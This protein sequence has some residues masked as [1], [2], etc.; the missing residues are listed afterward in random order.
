[1]SGNLYRKPRRHSTFLR[2]GVILCNG[3]L[4]VF[5]G[6][7]RKRTGEEISHIHSER[8]TALNL[9]D[10]YLYSGLLTDNDLLYQNQTFDSNHPGHHALPRMYLEDGWTSS[11]EDTMT[12]FVVWHALRRDWFRADEDKEGGGK[13][14]RLKR[15]SKLGVPGRSMVFKTRSR[16]ERDHWVLSI[17]MEIDRLQQGEDIRLV[18]KS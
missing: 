7:L 5:Q 10:C 13:K 14:Q 3:Q 11:D 1:M 2:C 12:C 4:L 17:G 9:A 15:L 6:S 8:V 16:A 18:S